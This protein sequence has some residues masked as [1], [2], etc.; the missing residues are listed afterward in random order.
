MKLDLTVEIGELLD[1][2]VVVGQLH[3]LP[4]FPHDGLGRDGGGGVDNELGA[5]SRGAPSRGPG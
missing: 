4:G 3:D 1:K 5:H 2:F